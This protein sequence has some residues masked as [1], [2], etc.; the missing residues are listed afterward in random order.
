MPF[1]NNFD[2]IFLEV[3]RENRDKKL[4]SIGI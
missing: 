4:N 1:E 2:K 3:L